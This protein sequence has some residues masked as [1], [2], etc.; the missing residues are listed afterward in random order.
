MGNIAQKVSAQDKWPNVIKSLIFIYMPLKS[1]IILSHVNK[2]WYAI[3]KRYESCRG[4]GNYHLQGNVENQLQ[5]DWLNNL[6]RFRP[7]TLTINHPIFLT[8]PVLHLM[9]D[10]LKSL[11]L[12]SSCHGN[13]ETGPSSTN[14]WQLT[15]LSGYNLRIEQFKFIPQLIS[16]AGYIDFGLVQD[17]TLL[18]STL[19]HL[20]ICGG[21]DST[22]KEM[23]MMLIH[24]SRL[25]SL[26]MYCSEIGEETHGLLLNHSY[27]SCLSKNVNLAILHS[28]SIIHSI[29]NFSF[30]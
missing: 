25:Q 11:T 3:S 23:Q 28:L 19:E 8:T 14:I 13:L 26:D 2:K 30:H 16:F 12:L 18:P 20:S 15:H 6:V 24:L 17:W 10:S 21:S 4:Q 7:L 29:T 27:L 9:K 22:D 1:H 5:M